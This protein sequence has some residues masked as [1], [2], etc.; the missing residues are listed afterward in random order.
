MD[1][2]WINLANPGGRGKTN[3]EAG[4]APPPFCHLLLGFPG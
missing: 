1:C 4:L 3:W 2:D